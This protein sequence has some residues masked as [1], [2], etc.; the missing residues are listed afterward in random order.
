M[1]E[2]KDIER[3][4]R[5][6]FEKGWN[7]AVDV[8]CKK[9]MAVQTG[10]RSLLKSKRSEL[11]AAVDR[12]RPPSSGYDFQK[13]ILAREREEE[14]LRAE[15]SQGEALVGTLGDVIRNLAAMKGNPRG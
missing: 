15:V 4:E 10:F 9:V 11:L 3:L 2:P 7:E 5:A 1:S 13:D 14:A 8:A 6:G 12:E